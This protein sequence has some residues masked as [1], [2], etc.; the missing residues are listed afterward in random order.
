MVFASVDAA[1]AVEISE[2][3]PLGLDEVSK[4]GLLKMCVGNKID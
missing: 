1:A 3:Q 2:S 4:P